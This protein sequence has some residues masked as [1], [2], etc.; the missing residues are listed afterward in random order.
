M[1]RLY[2]RRGDLLAVLVAIVAI[3]GFALFAITIF[4]LLLAHR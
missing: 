3:G 4:S 1:K 2:P